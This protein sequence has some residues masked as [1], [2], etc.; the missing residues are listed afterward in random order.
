MTWYKIDSIHDLNKTYPGD[1]TNQHVT[2]CYWSIEI[3]A[4]I[5]WG[6]IKYDNVIIIFDIKIFACQDMIIMKSIYLRSTCCVSLSKFFTN[7]CIHLHIVS[8]IHY[9]IYIPHYRQGIIIFCAIVL[10][11]S[12]VQYFIL[13]VYFLLGILSNIC[14]K[15]G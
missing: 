13:F 5:V 1:K 7:T 6:K 10:L 3:V 11:V 9:I 4:F 14:L 12:I 2:L 15:H 8:F